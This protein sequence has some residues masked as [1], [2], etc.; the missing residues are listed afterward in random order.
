MKLFRVRVS[1]AIAKLAQGGGTRRRAGLVFDRNP[2]LY[3][4]LPPAVLADGRLEVKEV[5]SS[6]LAEGTAFHRVVLG[7]GGTVASMK[8]ERIV[9]EATASSDEDP[10]PEIPE[11][12]SAVPYNELKKLAAALKL[13]AQGKAADLIERIEGARPSE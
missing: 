4:D 7:K 8:P 5:D 6:T 10:P 13:G 1:A 3:T 9:K 2:K 12:L 11:D